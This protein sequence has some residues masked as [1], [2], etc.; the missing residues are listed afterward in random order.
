M[1]LF[2][3]IAFALGIIYVAGLLLCARD[4]A[5]PRP[6]AEPGPP[7]IARHPSFRVLRWL[8]LP[9]I[10]PIWVLALT[11]W[12]IVYFPVLLGAAFDRRRCRDG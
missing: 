1:S 12:S 5:F 6:V 2:F 9:I 8:V 4:R 7:A 3:G 10:V 11:L